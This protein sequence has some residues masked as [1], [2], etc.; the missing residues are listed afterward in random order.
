MS[1]P[2][3]QDQTHQHRKYFFPCIHSK[4]YSRQSAETVTHMSL[5][6]ESLYCGFC[7]DQQY[8][9]RGSECTC[10]CRNVFKK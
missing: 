10:D 7:K 5:I 8:I 2:R 4:A 1:E 9:N 6:Q 3:L